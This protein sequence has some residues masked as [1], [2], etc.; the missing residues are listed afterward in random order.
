MKF[1]PNKMS[2]LLMTLKQFGTGIIVSTAFVHLFTHSMLM[3]QNPCI[4]GIDYEAT[5]AAILMAGILV[6]F[7]VEYFGQRYMRA[8][9][10]RKMANASPEGFSMEKHNGHMEM[11][12]INVMEAGIIF[13]SISESPP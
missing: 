13:H 7:L 8:R 2:I 10:A 6:S 4:E 1:L 3:F 9:L 11:V 12:N 5:A